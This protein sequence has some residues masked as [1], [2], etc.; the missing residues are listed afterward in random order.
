MTK[1]ELLEFIK[2]DIGISKRS[3][4]L[5]FLKKFFLSNY[6]RLM[7][8]YRIGHFLHLRG[9]KFLCKLL[10][11]RQIKI[12]S[13]QI[14]YKCTIGKN[15]SLPHPIGIVIGDGVIIGNNV[16][17]WQNVT[18]G[19]HGKNKKEIGYPII[20]D[21]VK[22]FANSMIIGGVKIGEN[23]KIGAM[24]LVTKN[25]GPYSTAIGSPAKEI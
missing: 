2:S 5:K 22:I 9:Y 4:F 6:F 1:R 10:K 19:S 8:N 15:L 13:C 20:D 24:S 12:Y 11:Y 18:L 14:S 7:L 25:I 16:S 17:I 3:V 23:A 21:G